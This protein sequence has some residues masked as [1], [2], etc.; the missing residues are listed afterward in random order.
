MT[1][2]LLPCDDSC[3]SSAGQAHSSFH[4]LYEAHHEH[5]M[6]ICSPFCSCACCSILILMVHSPRLFNLSAIRMVE[7]P[8]LNTSFVSTF[9]EDCWQPP[10]SI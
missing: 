1:L 2:A 10:R 9:A 7:F 3:D 4:S 8:R 6:D 5:E